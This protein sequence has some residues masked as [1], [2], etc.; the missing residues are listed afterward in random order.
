[1]PSELDCRGVYSYSANV[2]LMGRG[3]NIAP[4]SRCPMRKQSAR[5]A[6]KIIVESGVSAVKQTPA[7]N[8]QWYECCTSGV[9]DPR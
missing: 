7:E 8:T 6:H 5:A 4:I 1:M 3:V 9:S 2:K